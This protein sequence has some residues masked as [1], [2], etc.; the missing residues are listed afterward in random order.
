MSANRRYEVT[1]GMS[2]HFLYNMVFNPTNLHIL[3][4]IIIFVT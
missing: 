2:R 4:K 1:T 3:Q